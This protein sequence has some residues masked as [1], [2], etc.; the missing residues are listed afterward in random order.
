MY[1]VKKDEKSAIEEIKAC[2]HSA[3]SILKVSQLA[4][5][6]RNGMRRKKKKYCIIVLPLV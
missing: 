3:S 6:D 5:W 2:Q 4:K 1:T